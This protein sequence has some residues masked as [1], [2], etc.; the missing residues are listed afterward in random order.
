MLRTF[1]SSCVA[2]FL[3]ASYQQAACAIKVTSVDSGSASALSLALAIIDGVDVQLA[4]LSVP[5][6]TGDLSAIGEFS[7]GIT[8]PGTPLP[9]DN[10]NS[11]SNATYSGGIGIASGVCLCTGL[12]ND[13]ELASPPGRGVGVQGPN[14]GDPIDT[15]VPGMPLIVNEG[16]ISKDLD[17]PVDNDFESTLFAGTGSAGGDATVLEFEI[18]TSAP[19]FLRIS[20]VFSSDE[21][22]DW[23]SFPGQDINDAAVMFINGQ[24]ILLLRKIITSQVVDRPLTIREIDD[25]S[26]K[27]FFPNQIAPSPANM[28]PTDHEIPGGVTTYYD[29]EFAGFSKVLTFETCKVLPKTTMA[30]SHRIKIVIQRRC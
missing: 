19:G 6:I 8:A 3:V 5:S 4:P 18:E 20:L 14:N 29:H 25:C 27:I 23:V 2:L 26:P 11:A 22:P 16:E 1:F 10:Q 21:F 15:V 30:N 24:N 13:N 9:D 28:F 7:E 12:L 17:K